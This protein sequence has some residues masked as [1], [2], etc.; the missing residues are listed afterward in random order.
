MHSL[1]CVTARHAVVTLWSLCVLACGQ[2]DFHRYGD[3]AVTAQHWLILQT[4]W[5]LGRPRWVAAART[6]AACSLGSWA[7]NMD[8]VKHLTVTATITQH[9]RQH[10]WR[11]TEHNI[12]SSN[13]QYT[14]FQPIWQ[15]L[16]CMYCFTW[17]EYNKWPMWFGVDPQW[18][19]I[20]LCDRHPQ[21][22]IIDCNSLHLVHLM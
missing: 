10:Y 4:A 6:L 17:K 16:H 18:N 19:H 11:F 8:V 5:M 20:K 7:E 14:T 12:R 9:T 13:L 2:C 21:H 3:A 15:K 22:R 1:L